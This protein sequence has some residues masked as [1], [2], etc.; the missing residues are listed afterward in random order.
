MVYLYAG[1]GVAM[2]TGIMAI[3]EMGL[4]LTGSSLLPSP[5][6]AYRADPL[7]KDSDVTLLNY[8]HDPEKEVAGNEKFSDLVS[9][10]GLCAA[11]DFIDNEGW[12]L[13]GLPE[14]PTPLHYYW[15]EGCYINRENNHR[16]IV[17]ENTSSFQIFSCSLSFSGDRCP[18][19][20]SP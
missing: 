3:F 2:L 6:D 11:L 4:A 20:P 7:M 18:F 8:L 9:K 19:E 5:P 15:S 12:A 17:R 14:D 13:I 10:D 1:L 16:V